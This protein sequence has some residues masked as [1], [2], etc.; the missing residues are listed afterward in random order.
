MMDVENIVLGDE[1]PEVDA[2]EQHL[3][4][5][6]DDETG[7]DTAYIEAISERDANQADLID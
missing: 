1:T 5:D 2:A 4:V 3:A 7:L 6:V